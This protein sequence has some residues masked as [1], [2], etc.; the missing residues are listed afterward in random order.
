MQILHAIIISLLLT[1]GLYSG[2]VV[3]TLS[4]SDFRSI[5]RELEAAG[6]HKAALLNSLSEMTVKEYLTRNCTGDS[7]PA[8]AVCVSKDAS[9]FAAAEYMV[10]HHIHRVWI[11]SDGNSAGELEGVGIGCLSFTDIIKSVMKSLMPE[12]A[13]K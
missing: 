2:Q 12:E 10:T 1:N 5:Y 9:L 6:E 3:S 11:V 7:Y 4:A 13:A 8:P